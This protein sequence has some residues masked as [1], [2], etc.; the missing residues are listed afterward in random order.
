MVAI[1]VNQEGFREIL[2]MVDGA[3]E[4]NAGWGAFFKHLKVRVGF[5]ASS[6]LS[7]TV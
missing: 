2:G 4:D 3:K 1:G 6:R 7:L 5:Q